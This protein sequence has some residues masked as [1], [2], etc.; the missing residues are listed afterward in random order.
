MAYRIELDDVVEQIDALPHTAR[1]ALA[2]ACAL[3][4]LDPW[5]APPYL[6]A[7]PDGAMRSLVFGEHGLMV[8]L[9][10]DNQQRVDVLSALWADPV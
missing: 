6:A 8:L 5:S 2:E 10:L 9:V 7:N 4:E 3:L 1:V